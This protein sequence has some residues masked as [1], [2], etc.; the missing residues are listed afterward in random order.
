MQYNDEEELRRVVERL[1]RQRQDLIDE[2]K[3]RGLTDDQIEKAVEQ[4]SREHIIE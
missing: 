3:E 4:W 2:L 1:K